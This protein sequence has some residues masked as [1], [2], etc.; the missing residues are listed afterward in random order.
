M[1]RRGEPG[2]IHLPG[3]DFGKCVHSAK[4]SRGSRGSAGKEDPDHR[5][6]EHFLGPEIFFRGPRKFLGVRFLEEICAR[7]KVEV[8]SVPEDLVH[9]IG[10]LEAPGVFLARRWLKS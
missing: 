6:R 10:I 8:L 5:I 1:A 2:V 7:L 9:S 4:F 3:G